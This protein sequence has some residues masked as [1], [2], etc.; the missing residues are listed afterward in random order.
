MV[1]EQGEARLSLRR[2]SA[3]PGDQGHVRS[4]GCAEL[5]EGFHV[6]KLEQRRRAAAPAIRDECALTAVS[7]MGFA[8][9]LRENM[10]RALFELS[11]TQRASWRF[12]VAWRG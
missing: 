12:G 5:G 4:V 11:G 9:N 1:T 8:P 10:T 6:I 2:H 7:S 3:T